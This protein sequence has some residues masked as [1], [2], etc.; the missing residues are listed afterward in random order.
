MNKSIEHRETAIIYAFPAK[1][2]IAANRIAEQM[3]RLKDIESSSHAP[4]ASASGWYHDEAVIEKD[5]AS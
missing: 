5:K 3:R 2:R 1:P 4:I